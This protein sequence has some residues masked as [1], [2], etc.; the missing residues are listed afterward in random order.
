MNTSTRF[1]RFAW[2]VLIYN[3]LVILWGAYVRASGSGAGCGSHWPLCNGDVIPR[4]Q[5]VET[6]VE[7]THRL[8][9]GVALILVVIMTVWAYR[10]YPKHPVR[11]GAAISLFFI[12]TE[13]LV[14]AGLVL[15]GLTGDNDSVARAVVITIHLVNTFLLLAGLT[16]TIWWA[17]GGAA[18]RLRGQGIVGSLLGVG[19]VGTLVVGMAGAVTALG[20]TL[21]LP[22]S[23]GE[24][25]QQASSSTVHFLQRL[26]IVHPALAVVLS[27]YLVAVAWFV[28]SQRHSPITR[29]LALAVIALLVIQ[30]GAGVLN[31]W[32][33]VPIWMQLTHLLLAD[34]QWI[35][36]IGLTASVLAVRAEDRV[37][38]SA[39]G[40]MAQISNG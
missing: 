2:G 22:S 38:P 29:R 9:S 17:S 36:L 11:L 21:F 33:H 16:L 8:T 15:F 32:L 34:L 23:T 35:A 25:L 39:R 18:L 31:V 4:A 19:I 30:L 5:Y 14:G 26:R 12:I 37:L 10:A 28:R 13:A 27:V 40:A 3:L 7:F 20:D 6:L 24:V 1:V